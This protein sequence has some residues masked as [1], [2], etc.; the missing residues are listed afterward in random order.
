MAAQ[1]DAEPRNRGLYRMLNRLIC[2]SQG[3]WW[4][5]I[6]CVWLITTTIYFAANIQRRPKRDK[7]KLSGMA[8]RSFIPWVNAAPC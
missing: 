1:V 2:Y 4:G 8:G 7:L 3:L 6:F 5:V